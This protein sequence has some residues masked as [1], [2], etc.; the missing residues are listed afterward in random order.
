MKDRLYRTKEGRMLTGLCQGFSEHINIDVSIIRIVL[1]CLVLTTSFPVILFY[2][3]FSI[4]VPVRK[5]EVDETR[6]D[7]V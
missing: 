3:L 7:I 1:I 4:V 6:S 2:I 5:P